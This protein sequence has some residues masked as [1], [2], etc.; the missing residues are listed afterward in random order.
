MLMKFDYAEPAL[1]EG[2]ERERRLV[3]LCFKSNY[4][5]ILRLYILDSG[6]LANGLGG[7]LLNAFFKE[8]F[9]MIPFLQV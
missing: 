7:Y 3:S 9:L 2:I 1:V 6:N 5:F 8:L 4:L